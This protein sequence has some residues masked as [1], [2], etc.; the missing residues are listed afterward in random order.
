MS[1]INPENPPGVANTATT[2]QPDQATLTEET[3]SCSNRPINLYNLQKVEFQ[4]TRITDFPR[5]IS[6]VNIYL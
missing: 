5:F 4:Q 6:T 2:P 3:S 1:K